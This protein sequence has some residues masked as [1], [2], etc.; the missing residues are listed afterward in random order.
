[1]ME[2]GVIQDFR[3]GG[4]GGGEAGTSGAYGRG[5]W[6]SWCSQPVFGQL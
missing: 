6:L 3:F 4:G 2:L 5:I 1:M